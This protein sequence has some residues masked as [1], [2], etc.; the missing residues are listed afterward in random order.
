MPAAFPRPR[1]VRSPAKPPPTIATR[2]NL[3]TIAPRVPPGVRRTHSPA[4]YHGRHEHPDERSLRLCRLVDLGREFRLF[5]PRRGRDRLQ[6]WAVRRALLRG[7]RSL[8]SRSQ[9]RD[10]RVERR[11]HG[12]VALRGADAR[13][14]RRGAAHRLR[15]IDVRP[16]IVRN[17]ALDEHRA[18][19]ALDPPA[20]SRSRSYA[21][22]LS[23]RA[24]SPR[25]GSAVAG[26]GRW[27]SLRSR[28]PLAASS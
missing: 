26:A 15:R 1:A 10:D 20:R 6:L 8:A 13:P 3:A 27:A 19:A 18:A 12:L 11:H 28:L 25:V 16:R 2:S 24:R 23:R 7:L 22:A 14:S 4:G 9:Q 17:R 5:A 21:P